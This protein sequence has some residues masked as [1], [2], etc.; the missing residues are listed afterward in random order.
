ML[1][2][3]GGSL[4]KTTFCITSRPE[5]KSFCPWAQWPVDLLMFKGCAV[6]RDMTQSLWQA[7]GGRCALLEFWTKACLLFIPAPRFQSKLIK[8]LIEG[9]QG[10]VTR[11][12]S[13]ELRAWSGSSWWLKTRHMTCNRSLYYI[14]SEVYLVSVLPPATVFRDQFYHLFTSSISV[15]HVSVLY[16]GNICLF[17]V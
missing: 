4:S 17:P 5:H 1:P 10:A 7:H 12:V 11:V 16:A 8:C 9:N 13:H 14:M 6:D 3:S 15:L 2:V